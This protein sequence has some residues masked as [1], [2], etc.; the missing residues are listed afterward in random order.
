MQR[1]WQSYTLI[2]CIGVSMVSKILKYYF[3]PC[4]VLIRVKRTTQS[5][6]Y[7]YYNDDDHYP[8]LP[9]LDTQVPIK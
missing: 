2:D 3:A 7:Y 6:Y 9:H 8:R 1:S 4:C 5:F